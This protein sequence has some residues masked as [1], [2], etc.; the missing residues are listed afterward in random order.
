VQTLYAE[1]QAYRA[2]IADALAGFEKACVTL[3]KALQCLESR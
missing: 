1:T 3:G 2:A